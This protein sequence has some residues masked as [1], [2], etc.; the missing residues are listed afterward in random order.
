M[1][2]FKRK[3]DVK[4]TAKTMLAQWGSKYLTPNYQNYLNTR[5]FSVFYSYCYPIKTNAYT[6]QNEASLQDRKSV[7]I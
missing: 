2:I 6:P 7:R 4:G 1:E 3:I 5:Y